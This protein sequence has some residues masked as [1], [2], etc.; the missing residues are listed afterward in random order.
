M[1]GVIDRELARG[2][3]HIE[4]VIGSFR[5]GDPLGEAR[6]GNTV[7]DDDPDTSNA[8]LGP[9]S[10]NGITHAANA[11]H[12]T[13]QLAT[14]L[15]SQ[16]A[17]ERVT[18]AEVAVESRG[19]ESTATGDS[20]PRDPRWQWRTDEQA[21]AF[22]AR[23]DAAAT[24]SRARLIAQWR[25]AARAYEARPRER[26][27]ARAK[28]WATLLSSKRDVHSYGTLSRSYAGMAATTMPGLDVPS[29]IPDFPDNLFVPGEAEDFPVTMALGGGARATALEPPC[30]RC[31][32]IFQRRAIPVSDRHMRQ[33][34][35]RQF[36]QR[37]DATKPEGA[38]IVAPSG[39]SIA[40]PGGRPHTATPY[41][42]N[43]ERE[44][45]MC[46]RC[47]H[48]ISTRFHLQQQALTRRRGGPSR[49]AAMVE[50]QLAVISTRYAPGVGMPRGSRPLD[51]NRRPRTAPPR[52]RQAQ[53]T[54]SH[55]T[56]AQS[57]ST[58]STAA[59]YASCGGGA[60]EQARREPSKSAARRKRQA[61]RV[62]KAKAERMR[63]LRKEARDN[64]GRVQPLSASLR[65]AV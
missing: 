34:T 23:C 58:P 47:A 28:H 40:R 62:R 13:Q 8:L 51:R 4:G 63:R 31:M 45:P 48:L 19:T 14:L 42:R 50:A 21:A 30:D 36:E 35:R 46:E 49:N 39:L 7:T 17:S 38:A 52:S 27:A 9:H 15:D 59:S 64:I 29:L 43:S 56:R 6:E 18:P 32:R 26:V 16:G 1:E 61:A 22:A 5:G 37:W 41:I 53:R 55:P 2:V 54:N 60:R 11:G 24:Y 33:V 25:A 44:A 65:V 12:R 3:A 20:S 10:P 57:R